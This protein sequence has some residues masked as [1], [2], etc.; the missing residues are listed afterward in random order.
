M[1][2][3]HPLCVLRLSDSDS[4]IQDSLSVS[5]VRGSVVQKRAP[6]AQSSRSEERE[7]EV[8]PLASPTA[9]ALAAA[10]AIHP[11]YDANSL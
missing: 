1:D 5:G 11:S 6:L 8:N 4:L 7:R 3:D 9:A 2:R 10:A